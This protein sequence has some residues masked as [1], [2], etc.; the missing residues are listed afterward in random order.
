MREF[1]PE[2]LAA[3]LLDAKQRG[4]LLR[5]STICT[6]PDL[7][8]AWDV[9]ARV[10]NATKQDVKGWKIA[11]LAD[12]VAIAAPLSPLW[13]EWEHQTYPWRSDLGLEV[14]MAFILKEDLVAQPGLPLTRADIVNAIDGIHLGVELVHSR[15]AEGSS[16][17]FPL[18]L[19]DSLANAGYIL[20]PRQQLDLHALDRS[21]HLAIA[22]NGIDLF[23]S[24]T[25]HPNSDPLAPL[26][27]YANQQTG[28]LGGLKTGQIIT[29][30][31]LCGV[32]SVL[33]PEIIE[34]NFEDTDIMSICLV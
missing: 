14:E 28:V 31:S 5:S 15:L 25:T 34:I 11:L 6:P 29:T 21:Y 13:K 27:A 8:A 10:F 30:G 16:A 2:L 9:Q 1:D 23:L 32:L 7:A 20:G 33:K 4:E 26:V 12:G 3:Q 24:D 17:P 22:A 19:A 18:F